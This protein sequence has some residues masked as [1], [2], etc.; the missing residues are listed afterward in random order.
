MYADIKQ[1][2]FTHITKNVWEGKSV[3]RKQILAVATLVKNKY[4]FEIHLFHANKLS[5]NCTFG[6]LNWYT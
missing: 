4:T 1:I 5:C 2:F 6:I 3:K